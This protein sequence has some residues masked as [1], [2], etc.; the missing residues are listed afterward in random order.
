VS[1]SFGTD[2]RSTHLDRW[3]PAHFS[4][5]VRMELPASYASEVTIG[6]ASLKTGRQDFPLEIDAAGKAWIGRLHMVDDPQAIVRIT[7]VARVT[8]DEGPHAR[9]LARYLVP[10]G[11]T[12]PAATR[13]ILKLLFRTVLSC[14]PCTRR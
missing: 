13:I 10:N 1:T 3:N 14:L 5:A 6:L 4:D 2:R 9:P 12:M 11:R 7:Y 8:I